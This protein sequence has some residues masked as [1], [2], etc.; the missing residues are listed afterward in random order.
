M[1]VIS[2]QTLAIDGIPNIGMLVLG[3]REEKIAFAIVADLS[4][5]LFVS[6]KTYRFH[7]RFFL[8]NCVLFSRDTRTLGFKKSQK[9]F[10]N[11]QFIAILDLQNN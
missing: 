1:A 7:F 6:V 3:A 10:E 11:S 4:D 5:G 9:T 2:A 8:G